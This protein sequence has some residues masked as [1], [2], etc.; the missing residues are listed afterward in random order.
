MQLE[1]K[2]KKLA[3]DQELA[4]RLRGHVIAY[5]LHFLSDENLAL[6]GDAI[7]STFLQ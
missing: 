5:S 4:S 3:Q 7:L 2:L 1:D 6:L